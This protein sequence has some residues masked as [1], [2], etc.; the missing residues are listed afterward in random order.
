MELKIRWGARQSS[1][2][3]QTSQPALDLGETQRARADGIR[4]ERAKPTAPTEAERKRAQAMA[5][6]ERLERQQTRDD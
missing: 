2:E 5:L 1:S 3:A 6:T 4:A